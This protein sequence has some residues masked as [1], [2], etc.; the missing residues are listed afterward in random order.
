MLVMTSK[1]IKPLACAKRASELL[2]A[3]VA[4]RAQNARYAMKLPCL[5]MVQLWMELL[6]IYPT[7]IRWSALAQSVRDSLQVWWTGADLLKV[8]N[9][10]TLL[11][12]LL[13]EY[14]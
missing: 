3:K 6:F 2:K 14:V 1:Q 10:W 5:N 7:L 9:S 13:L 4:V 12:V 8:L 11:F